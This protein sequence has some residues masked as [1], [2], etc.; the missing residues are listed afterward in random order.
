MRQARYDS[1]ER[2]STG[3]V[4]EGSVDPTLVRKTYPSSVEQ[5][6]PVAGRR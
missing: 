1:K 3:T 2:V 4:G 6:K 5:V